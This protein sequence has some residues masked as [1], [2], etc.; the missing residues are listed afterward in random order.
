MKRFSKHK[1][2]KLRNSIDINMLIAEILKMPSKITQGRL[3][4]LCPVCSQFNTATKRQTNLARC[5]SCARNFNTIEMVMETKHLNFIDSACFLQ[6]LLPENQ[7]K[8]INKNKPSLIPQPQC[9]PFFQIRKEPVAME[10][11]VKNIGIG[12]AEKLNRTSGTDL[13]KIN[14]PDPAIGQLNDRINQISK[15]MDQ[16]K[17]FVIEQVIEKSKNGRY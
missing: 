16:L 12:K 7:S 6:G 1:L 5:F 11:L 13:V 10:T 15:Q 2:F 9:S 4:F 8:Q 14:H 3:R 17:S